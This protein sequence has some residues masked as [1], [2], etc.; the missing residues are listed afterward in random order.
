MPGTGTAMM[1]RTDTAPAV[2]GTPVQ[3]EKDLNP[4][5]TQ[6]NDSACTEA[7]TME[8]KY[9]MLWDYIQIVGGWD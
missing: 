2:M 8:E 6:V 3:Q 1:N 5:M 4:T 9:R 7:C